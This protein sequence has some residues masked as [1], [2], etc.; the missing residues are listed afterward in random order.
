MRNETTRQAKEIIFYIVCSATQNA[1]D[2]IQENPS[3]CGEAD[4]PALVR[5]SMETAIQCARDCFGFSDE[6]ENRLYD[7]IEKLT[8]KALGIA[9]N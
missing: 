7:R 4:Y 5:G 8:R 2:T 6:I 9:T 3:E 1:T